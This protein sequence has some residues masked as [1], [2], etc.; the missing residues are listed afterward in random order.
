[1]RAKDENAASCLSIGGKL[2]FKL[3]SAWTSRGRTELPRI[4]A[5]ATWST[6]FSAE[7]LLLL[8]A[9]YL[10]FLHSSSRIPPGFRPRIIPTA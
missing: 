9:Q 1:M 10:A 5:P 4:R 3:E 6:S 7:C 2:N 8:L